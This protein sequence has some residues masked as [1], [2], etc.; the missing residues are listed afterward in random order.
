[1]EA[2]RLLGFL[3]GCT[4]FV[5][6]TI[7]E[8]AEGSDPAK[9]EARDAELAKLLALVE[10]RRAPV[11]EAAGLFDYRDRPMI[12][13]PGAEVVII[14]FGSYVCP[15]C[16]RH[17]MQTMPRLLEHV[18]RGEVVYV[19]HDF[20]SAKE[21]RTTAEAALCAAEQGAYVSFREILLSGGREVPPEKLT[22]FA[23]SAQ[24]DVS[25]FTGCLQDGH[26][27]DEVDRAIET[28]RK[29]QIRGTPTFLLGKPSGES[30][31]VELV[32]RID[33]AQPYET[34]VREIEGLLGAG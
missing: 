29:L 24:L 26:H 34:F 18:E 2:T 17:A 3:A 31:R 16:K 6:A 28:A 1:V 21:N 7:G 8:A 11:K 22:D 5:L 13:E 14:E 25:E 27:V 4:W 32:R 30:G 23:Q 15:Y 12:G 20:P 33:G 10:K 19:Y 9:D